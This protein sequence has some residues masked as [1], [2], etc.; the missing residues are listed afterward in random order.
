MLCHYPT[1]CLFMEDIYKKKILVSCLVLLSI[2]LSA[3]VLNC[4][5]SVIF[6]TPGGR[7]VFSEGKKKMKPHSFLQK[8]VLFSTDATCFAFTVMV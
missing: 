7:Y 1:T 3:N 2:L 8:A 4:L 6:H 5:K